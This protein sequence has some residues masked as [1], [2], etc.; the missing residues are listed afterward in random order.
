MIRRNLNLVWINIL[1]FTGK[2]TVKKESY[3]FDIADKNVINNHTWV[4]NQCLDNKKI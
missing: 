4:L 1:S 2:E 3:V